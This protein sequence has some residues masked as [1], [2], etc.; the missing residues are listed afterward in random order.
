MTWYVPW[1]EPEQGDTPIPKYEKFVKLSY[2]HTI[3]YIN[4]ICQ[5]IN[6][7]MFSLYK[8]IEWFPL[9]YRSEHMGWKTDSNTFLLYTRTKFLP[10]AAVGLH[11]SPNVIGKKQIWGKV[12][13]W[14]VVLGERG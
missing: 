12:G 7:W 9:D 11:I 13:V 1:S 10:D 8:A 6:Y 3:H 2:G 14:H 4:T 5:F